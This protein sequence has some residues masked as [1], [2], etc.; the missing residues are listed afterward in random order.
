M[1]YLHG[2]LDMCYSQYPHTLVSRFMTFLD[3]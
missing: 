2:T 3:A 1:E